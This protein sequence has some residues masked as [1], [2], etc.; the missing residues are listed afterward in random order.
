MS[1]YFAKVSNKN[2]VEK[3][4][5]FKAVKEVEHMYK[6]RGIKYCGTVI[7]ND[8]ILLPI[9]PMHFRNMWWAVV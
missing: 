4:E 8:V 6:H 3:C 5:Q 1:M 9:R 7:G 2:I